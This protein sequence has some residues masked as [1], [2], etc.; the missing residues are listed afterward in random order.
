M[1]FMRGCRILDTKSVYEDALSILV[2]KLGLKM[3]PTLLNFSLIVS[4]SILASSRFALAQGFAATCTNITLNGA[5][6]E[7][8]TGTTLAAVC[9]ADSGVNV[10]SSLDLNNCIANYNGTLTCVHSG[11]FGAT[12]AACD[13][14][15]GPLQMVCMCQVENATLAEMPSVINLDTCISNQ[16]GSLA[17]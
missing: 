13:Y 14:G 9:E 12:C 10:T 6:M 4:I 15:I 3:H 17:C 7:P 8:T 1:T 11:D 16:N 2:Q 5:V